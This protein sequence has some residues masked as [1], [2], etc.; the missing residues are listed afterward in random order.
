MKGCRT[1]PTP[2]TQCA[3]TDNTEV[4]RDPNVREFRVHVSVLKES[5]TVVTAT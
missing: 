3:H 5:D 1:A 2:V 4:H